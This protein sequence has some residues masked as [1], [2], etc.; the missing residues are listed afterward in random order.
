LGMV[1]FS[2][3]RGASPLPASVVA[4]RMQTSK[5]SSSCRCRNS[6]ASFASACPPRGAREA[7]RRR[8]GGLY[9]AI[10]RLSHVPNPSLSGRLRRSRPSTQPVS[11]RPSVRSP[12]YRRRTNGGEKNP[13]PHWLISDNG[14]LSIGAAMMLLGKGEQEPPG[15]GFAELKV[16][17]CPTSVA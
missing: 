16:I 8:A 6:A 4:I 3:E 7:A 14:R 11:W 13:P 5:S 9:A 10:A 15:S 1:H 12:Q 17:G 2:G